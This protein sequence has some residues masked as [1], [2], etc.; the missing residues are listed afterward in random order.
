MTTQEIDKLETLLSAMKPGP[1]EYWDESGN[2]ILA[3]ECKDGDGKPI[4]ALAG[5]YSMP[6]EFRAIAALLNAAPD[7]LRLARIGLGCQ[8]AKLRRQILQLLEHRGHVAAEAIID[9]WAEEFFPSNS[10]KQQH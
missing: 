9:R 10:T 8:D 6:D 5:F 7:L 3:A 1:Y 4:A 2:D